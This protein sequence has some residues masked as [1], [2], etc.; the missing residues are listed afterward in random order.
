MIFLR[1]FDLVILDYSYKAFKGGLIPFAEL[2]LSFSPRPYRAAVARETR[3]REP[4]PGCKIIPP[5]RPAGMPRRLDYA[6]LGI[7]RSAPVGADKNHCPPGPL[8]AKMV[9]P[10]I[11][12]TSSVA[13]LLAR[14]EGLDAPACTCSSFS[15]SSVWRSSVALRF[16]PL[17]S[18]HRLRTRPCSQTLAPPHSLHL[19]RRRP[20][21]RRLLHTLCTR[22]VVDCA[23]RC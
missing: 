14:L 20:C 13:T 5:T 17:H 23:H 6:S 7:R 4:A 10:P 22:C 12:T 21:S 11:S 19:Q 8:Y 1:N 9:N 3:A 18:L 2:H 15:P 16:L